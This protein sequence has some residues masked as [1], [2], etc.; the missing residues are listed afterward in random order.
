M[1]ATKLVKKMTIKI[2][3]ILFKHSPCA[4][5]HTIYIN[6]NIA[7]GIK[8]TSFFFLPKVTSG[9]LAVTKIEV[10]SGTQFCLWKSPRYLLDNEYFPP[11]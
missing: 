4:V 2:M 9:S 7:G 6:G 3:L 8:I 1:P 11:V 10:G 5:K